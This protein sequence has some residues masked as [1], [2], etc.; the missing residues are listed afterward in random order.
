MPEKQFI[1]KRMQFCVD[2]CLASFSKCT[3]A[4]QHCLLLDGAH[5]ERNHIALLQLCAD[6]CVL[7][8]RAVLLGSDLFEEICAAAETVCDACA[9]DCS[10]WDDTILKECA[11]VCRTAAR[12]CREMSSEQE[13][14]SA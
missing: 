5:S 1:S 12:A 7:A 9:D 3:E 6:Q 11:R 13:A 8:A 10:L 2:S 14:L 4:I